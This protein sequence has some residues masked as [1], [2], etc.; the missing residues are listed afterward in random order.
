MSCTNIPPNQN[1]VC[2]H[3]VFMSEE[4]S[5]LRAC[6]DGQDNLSTYQNIKYFS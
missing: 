2:K 4:V 5:L 1:K 3:K 6:K